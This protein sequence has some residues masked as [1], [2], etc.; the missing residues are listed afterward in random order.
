MA[1]FRATPRLRKK[2]DFSLSG[3]G[4]E[5][6]LLLPGGGFE[7]FFH[8]E[9]RLAV[10]AEVGVAGLLHERQ[11]GADVLGLGV[12]DPLLQVGVADVGVGVV[13]HVD[14]S[15]RMDHGSNLLRF[16]MSGCALPRRFPSGPEGKSAPSYPFGFQK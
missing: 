14:G 15:N 7:E 4:A 11:N 3:Q 1:V 5:G 13:Y 6:V 2:S 12:Y 10:P 8:T 9:Q 16:R